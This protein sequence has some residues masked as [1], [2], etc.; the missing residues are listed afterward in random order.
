MQKEDQF[1]GRLTF[2]AVYRN[3]AS[4]E[5]SIKSCLIENNL[6]FNISEKSSNSANF[7]SYTI[8][9]HF[10]TEDELNSICSQLKSIEG[11]MMMF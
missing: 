3:K 4:I 9:A 5:D 7:N 1:P 6:D 2:K 10:E 8:E 11:F